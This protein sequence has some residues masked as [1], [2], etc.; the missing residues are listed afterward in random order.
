MYDSWEKRI[1][2]SLVLAITSSMAKKDQTETESIRRIK[3]V[4]LFSMFKYFHIYHARS[5]DNV[6]DITESNTKA[7]INSPCC[8]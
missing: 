1:F 6:M 7:L 5:K 2:N 8:S 4:C 3:Y